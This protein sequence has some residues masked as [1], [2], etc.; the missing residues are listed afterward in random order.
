MNVFPSVRN[1]GIWQCLR[2]REDVSDAFDFFY[3]EMLLKIS[4]DG[5]MEFQDVVVGRPWTR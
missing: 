1:T 2:W 5:F 4:A 3:G